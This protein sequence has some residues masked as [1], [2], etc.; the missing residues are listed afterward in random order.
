MFYAGNVHGTQWQV[1]W[2]DALWEWYNW[3]KISVLY[4]DCLCKIGRDYQCSSQYT[5]RNKDPIMSSDAG[6]HWF[7]SLFDVILEVL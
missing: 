4:L 2:H 5:G 1:I 7:L 3:I 6:E